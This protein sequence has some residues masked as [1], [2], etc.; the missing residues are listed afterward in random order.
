[1]MVQKILL[2]LLAEKNGV[3]IPDRDIL[4]EEAIYTVKTYSR[5]PKDPEY[6]INLYLNM[7]ES[8]IPMEVYTM[9]QHIASGKAVSEDLKKTV[10]EVLLTNIESGTLSTEQIM[11]SYIAYFI[12]N[13]Y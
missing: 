9:I 2:T 5:L 13:V 4:I 7:S 11:Y 1:M 6:F 12:L 3:T 8:F 10:Q